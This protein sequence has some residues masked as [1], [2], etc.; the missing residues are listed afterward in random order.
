MSE[1]QFSVDDILNEYSKKREEMH[2]PD[3][4]VDEFL[5]KKPDKDIPHTSKSQGFKVNINY[6]NDDNM[7]IPPKDK[8]PQTQEN[9]SFTS[10]PKKPDNIADIKEDKKVKE[11]EKEKTSH[12]HNT[13]KAEKEY[14]HHNPSSFGNIS[15][16]TK[17]ELKPLSK[18]TGNTEIIEGLL[19]LKKERI[20]SKTAEL[21]PVNRKNISDITLDIQS[22]IIPK[23]EQISIP[24]D[25]AKEMT[26][27]QKLLSLSE[28][29][30][31][32]IR[33]FV[34]Q[35]VIDETPEEEEEDTEEPEDYRNIEDAPEIMKSI[36]TLKG[37]LIVRLAF[38]I[39]SFLISGYI[40][41]AND[42]KWPIISILSRA[43]SPI[44]YLFV[45]VIL[46]LLSAFV[47]YN[48]LTAGIRN[49]FSL[50]ADSDSLSA[51][52][53]LIS[54][55]SSSAML[56]NTDLLQ[57]QKL[58]VYIPVAIGALLFNTIGKLLIVYR[59]EHNFRFVAGE[60]DK[61]AIYQIK[62]ERSALKFTKGALKDFPYLASMKKT[63]FVEDFLKNSYHSD[64]SDYYC[65]YA[66]PVIFLVSL[67]ASILSV[68]F[69]KEANDI[70]GYIYMALATMSGTIGI[71]SSF[72]IMLVV[73]IPLSKA[74]KRYLESSAALLGYSSVEQFK[75]TNSI[76][77]DTNSLFPEG[78]VDFVNLKQLSA[79]TIE[80]GILV[81]ASLANQ[82]NSV[83]KSA[84]YK[85]LKG[86]TEIL[87]PVDSYIYEDSLGISG[88][89]ENKRVLLGN[90][91]LMENHS[92]EGLPSKAK[93]HQYAKENGAVVYLSISGEVTTLFIV[94][95]K[96][97]IGVTKW[98]K[99]LE[100][101]DV[102]VVMHCVD[103]FI[104]LNYLSEVFDV[105]PECFK[106]LPFRYH[107][108]FDKETTYVPKID[109]PLL[110]SGRFQSFAMVVSGAK[111][112]YKTSFIGISFMLVSAAIGCVMAL[113]MSALSS[114][115]QLTPSIMILYNLIW[116][117]VTLSVQA[118]RKI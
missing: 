18:S 94:K 71:C 92:I 84:F 40:V 85:M 37:T 29:R 16:D 91:E 58:H 97:S 24:E 1:K 63:E 14:E 35:E 32:K 26:E 31:K 110:C 98:L 76:L 99:E 33:D 17:P 93:E 20:L 8:I 43:K 74:S 52:A 117:A 21:T 61:Y 66:V 62:D 101:L 109:S 57:R 10:S 45:L 7:F 53:I 30:N 95:A 3:F 100:K 77:I 4:D 107:K 106:L 55:I 73:N 44:S 88:W 23:T 78:T 96:A 60:G 75:D 5:N 41:F 36:V 116:A 82:A 9:K 49:L 6:D 67:V 86:K 118:Y 56:S 13:L 80:E 70:T 42:Y 48:V 25:I 64:I 113:V 28:K 38:L 46:G 65:K 111:R 81:A 59:T 69:T 102:T 50:K 79:T 83:M 11:P 54:L 108:D 90:R 72:A 115:S 114:F 68:I 12:R 47:C 39:A 19:K 103:S 34:L 22:K 87:Y 105:S 51:L 27:D 2:K 15:N 112:L 104:S 89:I